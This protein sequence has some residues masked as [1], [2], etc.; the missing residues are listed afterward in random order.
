MNPNIN[1]ESR[2]IKKGDLVQGRSWAA[3]GIV[4]DDFHLNTIKVFWF[5]SGK[6]QWEQRTNVEVISAS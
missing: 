1:A 5:D 2:K 4:L 6:A 3:Y